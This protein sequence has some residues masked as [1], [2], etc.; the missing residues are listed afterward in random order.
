MPDS[1]TEMRSFGGC[2]TQQTKFETPH[3]CASDAFAREASYIAA[4][5][6]L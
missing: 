5:F 3:A 1:A 2:A 6:P 4:S